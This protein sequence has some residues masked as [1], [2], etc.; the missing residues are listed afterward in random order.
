MKLQ[1]EHADAEILIFLMAD[2]VTG[3]LLNQS[4]PQGYYNV[5]CLRRS[6]TKEHRSRFAEPAPK[7]EGFT[8][9]V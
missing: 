4:T 5:G 3:A 8:I 9:S 7:G 1:Q 2:A 6:S